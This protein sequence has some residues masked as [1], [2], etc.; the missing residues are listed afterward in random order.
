MS[1]KLH[2]VTMFV[3]VVES[4]SFALAAERMNLTRSAVGKVINRLEARLGVRLLHR[5][6]RSQSLTEDGL[7]YYDRCVRALAELE[8]AE[9]DLESG[10]REPRGR[11]RVSVPIA[12]G[13]HCVAPVLWNL[14]R[15]HPQLQ[16]DISFSDRTVD[17]IEEGFDLAVRI[18]E[19]RDSTSLAARRLGVQHVGI[20]A[21]PSYL[22]QYGV[23]TNANELD[24]HLGIAYSRAGTVSPWE[25][26][27]EHGDL[28]RI[29]IQTQLS[30]DDVQ[31]IAGAAI[32]GFGLA[33]LPGWLLARYVKKG[34]LVTVMDSCRIQPQEIHAVWPQTRYLPLKTRMSIDALVAEIPTMLAY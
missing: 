21:A 7:A 30:L 14:A 10:R 3:Q 32:E 22:A 9:A 16:F 31:A 27:D 23:P 2:G 6:T 8:A 20:G 25:I 33:W 28:L 19:L 12:F 18:G 1:D 29:R 4:G 24:G 17:L 5:T 13:H 26:Q 34:E 11:L 15:R